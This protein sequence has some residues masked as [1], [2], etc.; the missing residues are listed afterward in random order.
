M[1]F[2]VLFQHIILNY[3]KRSINQDIDGMNEWLH[4]NNYLIDIFVSSRLVVT[5]ANVVSPDSPSV[6]IISH[7]HLTDVV[8]V[9]EDKDDDT[10]ASN[11][12]DSLMLASVELNS[13][14]SV[15]SIEIISPESEQAPELSSPSSGSTVEVISPEPDQVLMQESLD[16]SVSSDKTVIE[17]QY[18][19]NNVIIEDQYNESNMQA[20]LEAAMVESEKKSESLSSKSSEIVRVDISDT[21]SS[22]IEVLQQNSSRKNSSSHTRNNSD[23]SS[24]GVSDDAGDNVEGLRKKNKDLSEVLAARESKLMAVSREIVQLQE[25]SGEMSVRLQSALE[26][27]QKER[28]KNQELDQRSKVDQE[29]VMVLKKELMKLQQTLKSKGGD[30]QEKEEVI[31]DLRSEGEALAKQNGKLSE[32]IRKLRAKE[33]THDTEVGKFKTDLEKN[34]VEVERLRKS[35]NAKNEVEGTQSETIKSLTEANKAW[36][37]E[38]KK[39]KND[40]EDNVE[41]V[42]G[43][44]SSLEG[45][46]REMAEM[47]RKLEDAAGEAAAAALSKEVSLREEAVGKLDEERRGWNREKQRLELQ[48]VN[49]QDSIQM[50]EAGSREREEKLRQE[51]VIMRVKLED[52]DRR[53]EDMSDCVGQ[54]TKPLLRQIETLQS[55]LREV[56]SVQERVEQ[57]LGERLQLASQ[58]LALAQERERGLGEKVQEMSAKEVASQEQVNQERS[59][60]IQVETK[61]EEL[62][63]R[64]RN[65]EDKRV[66]E[67]QEIETERKS[68]SDEIGE[69]KKDKEYLTASLNTEKTES[70]GRRKKCLAL[71]DQLKERDRRVKELQQEME[72]RQS[73]TGGRSSVTSVSASPTPSHLS[74]SQWLQGEEVQYIVTSSNCNHNIS[75]CAMSNAIFISFQVFY[76]H[77]STTGSLYDA[78]A[79][80]G[81]NAALI[82]S[83]G[84]QIKQKEGEL[85]QLQ[86]LLQDH[87]RLKENMSQ[88]LTRLTILADQVIIL[89]S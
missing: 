53:Q 67:K 6:E 41:K 31:S 22:D 81:S 68:V 32:T 46:Y 27:V 86:V 34:V 44:R 79:R 43:L 89:F 42:L 88:E 65:I 77:S 48:I 4:L 83:M 35:L 9:D 28:F 54:A 26:Q 59:R 66:R 49:L 15:S 62:Q 52:S 60:R 74:D 40:L 78:A 61:L 7:D 57:S 1:Y 5:D 37:V 51:I 16:S 50:T 58:S 39:L 24:L 3:I 87:T 36:E 19:D 33:K 11:N 38:S 70:E 18:S 69:L 10:P 85:V 55:S 75:R 23:Q 63:E 13:P 45:A 73:M 8:K 71:M 30:D 47:K 25:E 72:H 21:T 17:D 64:M 12:P 14:Q 82:E 76:S 20:E 2:S 29:Q 56:T 80:F 84:A